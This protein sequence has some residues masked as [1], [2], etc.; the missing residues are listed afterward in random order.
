MPSPKK[1][2]FL[3][4]VLSCIKFP[5]DRGDIK[6]ELECHI[7]EKIDYYT[8]QGYDQE[9][10]EQLSINDMGDAKK[11]GIELNKQHNPFLGWIWKITNVMVVLF[12]IFNVY[13][14][15]AHLI[16]TLFD[17]NPI[18]NIPKSNIVYRIDLDEKVK[19]D[20]RIIN[21]TNVIYDK[22]GN[23]NIFYEYYNTKF[24]RT[25]WSLGTIGDITD[26][27]GNTYITGS[28]GGGGRIKSKCIWTA[29]NFSKEADTLI[30]NY[31]SYNRKYKVEIPLQVG[32]NNE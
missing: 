10:A 14:I 19:L 7:L 27:L 23:M 26:N 31:D 30:I 3:E 25:G 15:G 6:F 4:E 5:F 13:I 17:N 24:W 1:E 16:I 12:V 2:K 18:N 22:N 29:T 21:F 9:T 20:D 32:D 11:I 28:G 8:E